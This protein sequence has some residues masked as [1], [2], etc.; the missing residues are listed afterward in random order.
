MTQPQDDDPSCSIEFLAI[1]TYACIELYHLHKYKS[2]LGQSRSASCE[3]ELNALQLCLSGNLYLCI[4]Y[5]FYATIMI[6]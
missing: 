4:L 1:Q 6:V 2:P 3:G 5:C